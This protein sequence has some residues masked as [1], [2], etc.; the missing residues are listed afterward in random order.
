MKIFVVDD[1]PSLQRFVERWLTSLTEHEVSFFDNGAAAVEALARQSPCILVSDLDMPG[2]SGEEV[3]AAAARLPNPP[4]IVLMSGDH[5]RLE[6]ARPLAQATL[7]K[8]FALTE[9]LA[10]L[11]PSPCY[12]TSPAMTKAEHG[13]EG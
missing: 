11:Q 6:R 10:M 3:A 9:L 7:E 12:K 4:R 13:R 2:V 8:P 5:D 1:D